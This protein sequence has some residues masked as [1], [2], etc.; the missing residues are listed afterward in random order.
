MQH[1]PSLQWQAKGTKQSNA[2]VLQHISEL[3]KSDNKTTALQILRPWPATDIVE[4]LTHLPLSHAKLLFDWL[5]KHPAVDVIAELQ[6]DF[7]RLLL[8][9][10]TLERLSEILNS[11]DSDAVFEHLKDW[12][13]DVV[14][15][16]LPRLDNAAE[17]RERRSY[18][19]DSA[20]SVMSKKFV[21]VPYHWSVAKV[22]K[23]IRANAELIRSLYAVYV[24]DDEQ[25]LLGIVKTHRLLLCEK[26]T[27]VSEVMA[28]DVISVHADMDQEDVA[29]IAARYDIDTI[30]VVDGRQQVIGKI[31]AQD[32]QKIIR[33]EAQEDIQLM[34]GVAANTVPDQ[35]VGR[36]VKGRLPWLLAG[37]VGASIAAVV[38][39][40]FEQELEKAAILAS[41]IPI[42]MSMAGNA[43]IQAAT[44]AVQ[45]I[46][47]GNL[48]IGNLLPRLVRELLAALGNGVIAALI[49]AMLVTLGS[50]FV[51]MDSPLILALI[52][53]LSL[54]SVITI[55]VAV[56]AVIPLLLNR[57]GVDPAIATGVF[58]TTSNDILAVLIFFSMVT[59][60]YSL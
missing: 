2:K 52:A 35:S 40:G 41:F 39:A 18:Q 30:P 43:G 29:R 37:M 10:S 49:L 3:I 48:W 31:T 46:A 50:H 58:I 9:E 13:A 19:K 5:P 27:P 42:V 24:L 22:I 36:I 28:R 54:I 7:R 25:R 51:E 57:F 44:V 4:L 11:L 33:E 15:N 21:A 59:T 34:A 6:A 16:I 45:G 47:N 8:E 14:S 20:G 55:A 17:I 23:K 1:T 53:G 12:P 26:D 56:G 38:V 60:F 32:F